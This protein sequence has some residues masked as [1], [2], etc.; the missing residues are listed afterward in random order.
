MSVQIHNIVPGN[1]SDIHDEPH[2]AG[3]RVTVQQVRAHVE[4]ADQTPEHVA[5]KLN[6]DIADVYAALSYYHN[7]PAEMR[8]V[9]QRRA[10]AFDDMD[11]LRPPE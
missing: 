5:D 2:I 8:A 10:D 9:E 3:S 7:N 11:E 1:E 4:G 6:L